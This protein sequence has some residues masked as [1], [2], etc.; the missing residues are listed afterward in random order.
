[1][2]T[3]TEEACIVSFLE[4][5]E[6]FKILTSIKLCGYTSEQVHVCFCV[7]LDF[8]DNSSKSQ[9]LDELAECNVQC[10]I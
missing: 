6:H 5:S 7:Y 1:M 8:D 9:F 10:S 2:G 4:I 3:M